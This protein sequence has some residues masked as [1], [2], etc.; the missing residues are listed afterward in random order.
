M[1]KK[2][3]EPTAAT[4]ENAMISPD[5]HELPDLPNVSGTSAH[6]LAT[7][8]TDETISSI[9]RLLTYSTLALAAIAI[10]AGIGLYYFDRDTASKLDIVLTSETGSIGAI[11]GK[12]EASNDGGVVWQTVA[13]GDAVA[14]GTQIRA[15]QDAKATILLGQASSVELSSKSALS[16]SALNNIRVSLDIL[17]GSITS[18]LSEKE[19]W[20]LEITAGDV[21]YTSTGQSSA[22]IYN[23]TLKVAV[24]SGTATSDNQVYSVSDT[25]DLDLNS[26]AN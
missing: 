6:S 18:N 15:H 17:A 14:P 13:L 11:E 9:R 2:P 3:S 7:S 22:T 10:G 19:T 24:L 4:D 5:A 26:A 25:F 21:A 16:I 23:N 8:A 1:P 12:V 20:T